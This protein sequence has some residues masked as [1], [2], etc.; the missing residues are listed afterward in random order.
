MFEPSESG[1]IMKDGVADMDAVIL[2]G[3]FG[4]RLRPV[5]TDRPKVMAP[6]GG[7][8]FLS[9]L[10]DHLARAGITRVVLCI[11]HLGTQ[12]RDF[13]G[14][15]YAGMHLLYSKEEQPLETGGA[16]RFALPLL[17]SDP[18][19]VLNGDSFCDVDFADLRDWHSDQGAEA[20]IAVVEVPNASRF[21]R[22][23]FDEKGAITDFEEK[24]VTS[25]RGWVNAGI[26]LISRA[27]ILT[28]PEGRA[29][30][31]EREMFPLWAQG[32]FRAY[33]CYGHFIDIGTPESYASAEAFFAKKP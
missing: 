27:S 32:N 21:G 19:L 26:Y 30:S 15:A 20:S 18:V 6:V 16:L 11:G 14:N 5:I 25:R 2:A 8:P 3:G 24:N 12:V 1:Q 7:R 17:N 9:R 28:I 23:A 10:L 31:L 29:V 33:R 22:V 13:F 4:T